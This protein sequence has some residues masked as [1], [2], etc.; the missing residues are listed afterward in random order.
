MKGFFKTVAVI[1]VFSVCEKLLGFLYRIFLSRSVGAEGVG[2]YQ[3]ALSI[4]GLIFTVVSSGVPITVSRLMTKYRA[5]GRK[6]KERKVIT[7]GLF[8]TLSFSLP[9]AIAVFFFKDNLGFLFADERCADIFVVLTFGLTFTSLYSVFRGVFWGNKDFIPYSV[10]ELLEEICMIIVG[11]ILISRAGDVFTGAYYAAI[12]VVVSFTF[13]FSLAV[14]TF[15]IRKNKLSDPRSEIKPLLKSATPIT[16][17]RTANSLIVSLVSAVLPARL[18]ASGYTKSQAMSAFGAAVG[19]A[20]PILFIPSTLISAFI[21]VLVPELSEN[22]Y[23]GNRVKV[24]SDVSKAV[25][26]TC[27]ISSLFIPAFFCCGKEIGLIVFGSSESGD[28]LTAS[29]FMMVFMG[30]SVITTSILNSVGKENS[31]LIYYIAGTGLMLLSVWILP[32]FIGVY[33]LT[34]GYLCVYTLTTA[35]NIRL[36]GKTCGVKPTYLKFAAFSLLFCIPCCIFG[37]LLKNVL[38]AVMPTFPAATVVIV[39]TTLMN[40]LLYFI[41]GLV[42]T[43]TVFSAIKKPRKSVA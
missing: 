24:K 41:F 6:D 4:F 10:I 13:S 43:V 42:K 11:I 18:I 27:F 36:I 31:T 15:F 23:R 1:T 33:S 39:L 22:F 26:F 17:M 34:V 28:F 38:T 21:V 29:S 8:I 9:V 32:A 25:K 3:V 37:A 16:A 19:Q 5:E 14:A 7:A 12:A 35:L 20:V 2:L 40:A 30:T